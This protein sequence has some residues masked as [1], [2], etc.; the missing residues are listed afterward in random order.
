MNYS[1]GLSW[2]VW[3]GILGLALHHVTG[4]VSGGGPLYPTPLPLP[5]SLGGLG[6]C[7]PQHLS[8]HHQ[9][10][11]RNNQESWL[12]WHRIRFSCC[13]IVTN[14]LPF[15]LKISRLAQ[16][17]ICMIIS[18]K[19]NLVALYPMQEETMRIQL[20]TWLTEKKNIFKKWKAKT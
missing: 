15:M 11:E 4:P 17:I 7:V 18:P 2:S 19:V 6:Q 5:H 20:S 3:L 1:P 10:L 13:P 8:G 14:V 9:L 12:T 16:F